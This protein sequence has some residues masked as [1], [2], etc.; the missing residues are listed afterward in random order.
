MVTETTSQS[1]P[2]VP[3]SRDRVLDAAVRLADEHGI[4]AVT[5]R[6]LAETL[7][8]EAMSLYYHVANKRAL[9]DG[10]VEVITMEVLA[11]VAGVEPPKNEDDWKRAMR[12]RILSARRVMLR[13]PWAPPVFEATTTMNPALLLYF[14]GLLEVFRA[15]GFSWDLAH[16]AMHALGSRALGFSQELFTPDTGSTDE[17]MN[18][19]LFEQ[20]ATQLPLLAAMMAEIAHDEDEDS[21]G[22]C[23]DETEFAFALDLLLDGLDRRR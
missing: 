15:G 14:N 9:L 8:V 23:D 18:E 19:E 4:D 13:H 5:M 2:R 6:R 1:Q 3:L 11:E 16:H 20:M 7:G 21:L 17:E 22:W 12:D 10:V